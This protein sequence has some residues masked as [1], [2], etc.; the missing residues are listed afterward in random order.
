VKRGLIVVAAIA[1]VS[2]GIAGAAGGFRVFPSPPVDGML[3]GVGFVSPTDGWVVGAHPSNAPDDGGA[4]TLTEHWNGS[5]WSVVPSFDTLRVDDTLAAVAGVATNDVWA[6]GQRKPT[7]SKSPVTPLALHWNGSAWSAVPTPSIAVTRASLVGVAA[8][9]SNNAWAVGA[10]I[11]GTLVEH[12]NGSAW[13]V[14][15]SPNRNGTATHT[16][17]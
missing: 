16:V 11:T 7:G 15:P 4:A 13:S 2:A 8:L 9:A 10:T 3:S 17:A 1:L 6:V 12:W 14:V 5:A